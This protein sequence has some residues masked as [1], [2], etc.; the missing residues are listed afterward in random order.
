MEVEYIVWYHDGHV[1]LVCA[2]NVTH[3]ISKAWSLRPHAW[4]V[5][6]VYLLAL[7]TWR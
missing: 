6:S 7:Y 5:H 3:A 4:R 2:T 1:E